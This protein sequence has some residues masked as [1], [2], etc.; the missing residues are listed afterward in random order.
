MITAAQCKSYLTECR[1]VGTAPNISL[2]R[3]TAAMAIC[4]ALTAL[5][6][7]VAHYDARCPQGASASKAPVP[8]T[9]RGT[10]H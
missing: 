1:S 10:G 2:Q 7:R 9:A 6:N 5:A 8:P 4:Q 3:A